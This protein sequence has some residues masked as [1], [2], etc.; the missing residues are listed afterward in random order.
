M[1]GAIMKDLP[2]HLCRVIAERAVDAQD[3]LIVL[4][5]E[6]GLDTSV[7]FFVSRNMADPKGHVKFTCIPERGKIASTVTVRTPEA[8]GMLIRSSLHDLID[9]SLWLL[10]CQG[11]QRPPIVDFSHWR[12]NSPNMNKVANAFFYDCALH[13]HYEYCD[14]DPEVIEDIQAVVTVLVADA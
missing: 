9:M 5:T 11:R 8:L 1:R 13:K 14:N 10:Y 6:P 12:S 3:M 2:D 7:Q 4:L